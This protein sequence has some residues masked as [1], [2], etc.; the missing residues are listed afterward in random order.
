[1]CF[2][3]TVV[4]SVGYYVDPTIVQ[5]MD[6]KHQI[7]NAGGVFASEVTFTDLARA[8]AELQANKVI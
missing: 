2:S 7:M 5:V 3:S 1:M 8:L 6:P 4:D